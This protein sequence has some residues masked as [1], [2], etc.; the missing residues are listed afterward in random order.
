MARTSR[1]PAGNL[2]PTL[3]MRGPRGKAKSAQTHIQSFECIFDS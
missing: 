3:H 2:I 1:T